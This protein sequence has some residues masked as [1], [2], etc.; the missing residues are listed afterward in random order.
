MTG[1]Q[2]EHGHLHAR[3]LL[4]NN[5]LHHPAVIQE[6]VKRN[7]NLQLRVADAITAFAGSMSFVYIHAVL[8]AAWMLFFERTP[9]PT[10]TLVVSL[11]AIF[12]S[13]FVMIGQNRQSEFQQ[14]KADHDFQTQEV[15]LK[16]N[17]QLTREIHVLTTE[18][19]RRIMAADDGKAG[20]PS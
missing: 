17:T 16:T 20:G 2:N 18:L 14:A 8:F 1:Q 13:T 6:A 15:E 11:E 3:R 5:V 10:L 19:H 7:Q 4:E 12:L 9:W